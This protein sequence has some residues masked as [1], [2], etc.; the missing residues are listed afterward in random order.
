MAN[1]G[2]VVTYE[3]VTEKRRNE[4]QIAFMAH[5]D[6]LTSLPNRVLFKEHMEAAVVLLEDRQQF[7]VLCLDLDHFKQ[8]NDALGH[9]AGDDLLRL[10]A[11][12]LRHCVRDHDVVARLGGDEF[13]ILLGGAVAGPVQAASLAARL[14]ES[15][16][17][18]YKLAGRNIVIGTSIGIALSAPG[19]PGG[20]FL[21]RADVALYRAKE[22]RGTFA[23]YEPSMDAHLHARHELEADLRLAVQRSEFEL[24]YQPL[25]SLVEDR[26]TGF[27][28]LVRWNSPTRGH[29]S[30]AD[31][32]PLAEQTG[33]I[34]PIGEWVLRTACAEAA[35]W[36]E[37][38]S[39]AV[40]LS[41]V[42]CKNQRLLALVRETLETSGLPAQRLELEITETVLLQ[43][44]DAVMALLRSLHEIG[45]RVAM[46]DFGTGYS[47][48][49]YLLRF[50]F[51]KI[52]I[53]RSFVSELRGSP[54]DADGATGTTEPMLAS[55]RSAAIIVR[56]I[57][58]LANNLGIATIA[59]GVETAE[60]F[61]QIRRKGCTE[62]QGYFL[63]R[64][65]P[66][67]EVETLRQRL[68]TTM[69]LLAGGRRATPQLVA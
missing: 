63:S 23:F 24:H 65:R 51:D 53:D 11:G 20:E 17:A 44:T 15:I 58:G 32:I 68:D 69:P 28:A 64:P 60:Q 3:D 13:A 62:V 22:E 6:A 57:I 45:V 8:V 18:P 48:L 31:F 42:Q 1:G 41:P 34:V 61:A 36:P 59:E 54:G 55:A 9:A 33:L 46:D 4:Q 26:V 29:V 7:A 39:V 43:D 25:Y 56:T 37:H 14:V 38:V 67:A 10:V 27:E 19:I 52:K 30:P 16:G 66:A 47:S 12:R 35:G 5:H 40:N 2:T 21:K 49:N 50:P